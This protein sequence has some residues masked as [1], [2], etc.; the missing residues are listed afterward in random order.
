MTTCT[1][2][3]ATAQAGHLTFENRLGFLKPMRT[4]RSEPALADEGYSTFW[5]PPSIW[6]S[7]AD[8]LTAFACTTS[9]VL[10][11]L[12]MAIHLIMLACQ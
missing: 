12:N 5:V 2:T 9:A 11:H 1:K 4:C 10:V 8:K 3:H 7:S 6:G